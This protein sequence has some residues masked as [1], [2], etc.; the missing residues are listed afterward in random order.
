MSR[1]HLILTLQTIGT[2]E[3][4]A[5]F[6]LKSV[7][8]SPDSNAIVVT[9]RRPSQRIER[10]PIDTE[11]PLGRA[12]MGLFGDAKANLHI[13]S[14]SF[15]NGTTSQRVMVGIKLPF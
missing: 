10:T 15:S 11:P 8:P 13:E 6:N 1:L 7:K 14:Q 4:P 9:A 3:I 5:D 12:E 2:G